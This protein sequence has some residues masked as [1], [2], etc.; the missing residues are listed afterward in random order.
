[1]N[2]VD[3]KFQ[4][5]PWIKRDG[6]SV[7]IKNCIPRPNNMVLVERDERPKTAWSFEVSLFKNYRTETDELVNLCFEQDWKVM[8]KPAFKG[9]EL[10]SMKEKTKKIY[11]FVRQVYRR[12][13]ALGI[14]GYIFAIGW[15]EFRDFI[16][17]TLDMDDKKALNKEAVDLIFTFIDTNSKGLYPLNPSRTLVR[18]EFVEALL[19]CAIK[20]YCDPSL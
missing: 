18:F 15:N 6:F 1:V 8:K 10:D 3:S 4:E 11:P 12:L 19:R 20:K 5:L 13:S 2:Y 14:T 17:N 16:A 7:L 9:T